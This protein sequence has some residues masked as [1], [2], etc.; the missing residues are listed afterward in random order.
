MIVLQNTE[1]GEKIE[2]SQ[3]E[4]DTIYTAMDS[5][6]DYGGEYEVVAN[7]IQDKLYRI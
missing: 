7:T 3:E 2:L 6:K 5:Y 4:L 1:T